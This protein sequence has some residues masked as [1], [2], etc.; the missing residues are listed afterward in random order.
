MEG[1]EREEL[2]IYTFCK[3]NS[4]YLYEIIHIDMEI[5]C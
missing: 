5:A 3:G 1:V 4:Y 2:V